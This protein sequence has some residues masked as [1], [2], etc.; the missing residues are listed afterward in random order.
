VKEALEV[1]DKAP[2]EHGKS[3]QMHARRREIGGT[4]PRR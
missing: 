3:E 4:L 1:I 2:R